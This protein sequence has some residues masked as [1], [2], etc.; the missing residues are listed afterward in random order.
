MKPDAQG[1]LRDEVIIVPGDL[2][3]RN[4][5]Y[6]EFLDSYGTGDDVHGRLIMD[7]TYLIDCFEKRYER[8]DNVRISDHRPVS[9][10]LLFRAGH[11]K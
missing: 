9:V 7:G 10:R 11:E 8:A 6:V 3:K 4:Y 2:N 1:D 5:N